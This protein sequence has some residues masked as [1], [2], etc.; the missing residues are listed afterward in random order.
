MGC[1]LIYVG[2]VASTVEGINRYIVGCKSLIIC[3]NKF[4]K[5]GINRYIVG[6]KWRVQGNHRRRLHELID[7]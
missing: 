7:T 6:C 3:V 1:K 2:N 4:V 5:Y